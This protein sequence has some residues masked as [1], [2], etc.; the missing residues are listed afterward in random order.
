MPQYVTDSEPLVFFV[1]EQRLE[2]DVCDYPR[3]GVRLFIAG[4]EEA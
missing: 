2:Q 1:V 4:E 3:K